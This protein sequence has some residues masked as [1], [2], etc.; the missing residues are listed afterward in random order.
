MKILLSSFGSAPVVF[1]CVAAYPE[2]YAKDGIPGHEIV[3]FGFNDG[4]DIKIKPED[5][6]SEV[7]KRLPAN[8]VP[9]MCILWNVEWYLLPKGIES[10]PFPTVAVEM[11]WDYDVPL[12]KTIVESTD[13][14]IT[15]GDFEKEALRSLGAANVEIFYSQGVMNEYFCDKPPKINEREYDIFYSTLFVDDIAHPDRSRWILKLCSL[16]NKYN[17]FI[18]RSPTHIEYIEALRKSKLVFTYH[19]YGSMSSRFLDA[20]AQGSIVLEPGSEVKEYFLPG[21]EYIPITEDNVNEQIEKYLN[22]R[23][24][25]QEMSDRVYQKTVDIY[26]AKQRFSG[27]IEFIGKFLGKKRPARKMC[28]LTESEKLVRRGEVYYYS[29]FRANPKDFFVGM[30]SNFLQ[31]SIE[32]FKKAVTIVPS[33]RGMTNLAIAKAAH[34]F[35]F[36]K[37]SV[38][39]EQGRET[40]PLLEKVIS[41]YPAYAMA[42]FNL[43]LIHMRIGNYNKAINALSKAIVLFRDKESDVDPWCLHNRDFDLFNK[44]IRKPLNQNLLLLCKGEKDKA[45]ENI[46]RL[47]QAAIQYFIALIEDRNGNVYKSL[48]AIVDSYNLHPESGIIVK[49]AAQKLSLL[50]FKDESLTLYRESIDLLPMDMDLRLEYIRILYLY[51]RDKET[52]E[53]INNALTITKV[54]PM[55]REKSAELKNTVE[56]LGRFNEDLIYSHDL[57]QDIVL[58]DMIEKLFSSLRKNPGDVRVVLRITDLY[59]KLGGIDRAFKM[60][61]DFVDNYRN[62]L[63]EEEIQAVKNVYDNLNQASQALNKFYE[64]KLNKLS[65][66]FSLTGS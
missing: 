44:I 28:H 52:L 18:G 58:N 47:Y 6:F 29:F 4:V 27:L 37:G 49:E 66:L 41:S 34:G 40:I 3:T 2:N 43:G 8:W 45:M 61:E 55:F 42:H 51:H 33:P 35:I 17:V 10:A 60:I 48:D 31:L 24:L 12:S 5:D 21:K 46:R 16:A 50:G 7:V 57:I 26:E 36:D 62:N 65:A 19:R 11:D 15:I 13:L 9:D 1:V 63:N 54:I 25:L 39:N 59:R 32:E 22:N 20:A 56:N 38:A 64:E 53:E 23:E 30:N 14:A